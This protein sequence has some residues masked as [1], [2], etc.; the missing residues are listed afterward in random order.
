M[1]PECDGKPRNTFVVVYLTTSSVVRTTQHRRITEALMNNELQTTLNEAAVSL[2]EA[3]YG[4]SGVL[5]KTKRNINQE[6]QLSSRDL[7]PRPLNYKRSL[8]TS[9][10]L[11]AI[12]R[13][14]EIRCRKQQ[15]LKS[16]SEYS[17]RKNP[18]LL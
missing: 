4:F 14:P 3:Y 10:L 18:E 2:S 8:L 16:F 6:S 12:Q 17:L 15:I 13:M 11:Q 1:F 5:K 9:Q 7:N